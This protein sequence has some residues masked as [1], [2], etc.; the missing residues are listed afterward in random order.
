MSTHELMVACCGKLLHFCRKLSLLF[1]SSLL[2]SL[3]LYFSTSYN[4]VKYTFKNHLEP[5]EMLYLSV[6]PIIGGYVCGAKI[7]L[8]SYVCLLNLPWIAKKRCLYMC[9]CVMC[10]CTMSFNATPLEPP[11]NVITWQQWKLSTIPWVFWGASRITTIVTRLEVLF[12][13]V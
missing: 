11:L 9:M 5:E 1:L 4:H 13:S 8:W 2:W 3:Y 10:V 12:T 7:V 6:S